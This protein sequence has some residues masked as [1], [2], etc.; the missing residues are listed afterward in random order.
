MC[1]K[2]STVGTCGWKVLSTKT[3]KNSCLKDTVMTRVESASPTCFKSCGPRNAT[4]SCWISCFFD[5]LLG[6]Q[7]RHNS[8]VPLGGLPIAEVEKAWESS[9]LPVEDGGCELVDIQAF[10]TPAAQT[11]VI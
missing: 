4:S 6:T 10:G 7:A 8:S 1:E 3:V 5:A 11:I 2:T 9:F